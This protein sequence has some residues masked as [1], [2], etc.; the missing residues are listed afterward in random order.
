M[1]TAVY[2]A[3]AAQGPAGSLYR[4]LCDAT[5]EGGPWPLECVSAVFAL[6]AISSIGLRESSLE[7]AM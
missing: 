7:F 1:S 4:S 2:A 3:T 5:A 6:L